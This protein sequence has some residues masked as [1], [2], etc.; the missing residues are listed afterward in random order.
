[1][2]NL[3]IHFVYYGIHVYKTKRESSKGTYT[4]YNL[5]FSKGI[6]SHIIHCLLCITHYEMTYVPVLYAKYTSIHYTCKGL[7]MF[8]CT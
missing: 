8:M 5:F 1:M 6:L 2:S 4:L 7:V 3:N